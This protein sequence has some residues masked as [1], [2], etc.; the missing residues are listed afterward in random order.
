MKKHRIVQGNEK[1]SICDLVKSVQNVDSKFKSE[2]KTMSAKE[3]K[4]VI[5]AGKLLSFLINV[6]FSLTKVRRIMIAMTKT[7]LLLSKS[8]YSYSLILNVNKTQGFIFQITVLL[9][10]HV[11]YES[12]NH[13]TLIVPHVVNLKKEGKLFSKARKY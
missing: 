9:T 11:I 2:R 1:K 6:I 7:I 12:I 4:N 5:F 3:R 10:E 8:H 13:S